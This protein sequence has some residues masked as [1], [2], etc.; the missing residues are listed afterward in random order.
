MWG[1][2]IEYCISLSWCWAVV[3]SIVLWGIGK[4]VAMPQALNVPTIEPPDFWGLFL[5]TICI[6]QFTIALIIESRYEK[7]LLRSIFWVIWY[8]FFFW[9]LSLAA[10]LIGFPK[11]LF[12]LRRKRAVWASSDRG[13]ASSYHR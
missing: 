11:A 6:I 5:A 12:R 9:T 4:F 10:S 2:V 13:I 8:P 1:L 3:A 7:R